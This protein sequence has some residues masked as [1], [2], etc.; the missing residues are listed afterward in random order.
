VALA[1]MLF[2]V[3]TSGAQSPTEITL[4][5]AI[6]DTSLD[7]VVDGSAIVKDIQPG[8]TKNLSSSAGTQ[9][10]NIE[11]IDRT[12]SSVVISA[13]NLDLPASG[14]HS[15][16]AHLNQSGTPVLTL[17]ENDTDPVARAGD[18]RLTFRHVAAVPP[19]DVPIGTG[20]LVADLANGSSSSIELA[21]GTISDAVLITV[22]GD[23]VSAVPVLTVTEEVDFIVYVVGSFEDGTVT[24][25]S[26]QIALYD[27]ATVRTTAPA[28]TTTTT[29]PAATTT[30]T[31]PAATTTTTEPAATTTTT[32]PAAT[33]TTTAPAA[34][35]EAT[36]MAAPIAVN[37]GSPLDGPIDTTLLVVAIGS[38]FVTGGSMLARRRVG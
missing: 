3:G 23:L 12:D 22:G 6:P 19:L 30:T 33:T 38:F 37:T 15:L 20:T 25:I 21:P 7:F 32:E 24:F 16:V 34:T 4:V 31:E 13:G 11:M 5:N 8:A 1:T 10:V 35:T 2:A 29:E 9:L 28:A 26:Q 36:L 14:S 18:G 17:F 27:K